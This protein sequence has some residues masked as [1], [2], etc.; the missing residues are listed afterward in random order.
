MT[1]NLNKVGKPIC[2]IVGGKYNGHIVS[3]SDSHGDITP[4]KDDPNPLIKEFKRLNISKDSKLQHTINPNTERQILYITGC[5]GSG[6]SN[7]TR[8][9]LEEYKKKYKSH[10]IYLFSSLT[11]DESLDSIKPKR[12]IIYESLVSDPIEIS[13]LAKSCCIFDDIDVISN[14][15]IREAV[16]S[17]LNQVSEIGRHHSITAVVT[18]H[19]PSNGHET[20]RILNESSSITYFPHSAS[21]KIK[22]MLDNHVGIDRQTFRKFKK[23]NSR[24]VTIFRH[25]PQ[26][27][28]SENSVGL[29]N[30]DS[31]DDD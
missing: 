8:K 15:K 11:E 23:L 1:L 26:L 9:Y 19:L 12:I 7:Y 2:K 5:S 16:Y 22:D 20:R 4:D 31:D 14:K 13:E 3:V 30:E 27:Y 25:Y 29:L 18:C 17:V 21:A 28:L 10:P 24:Y 6:K